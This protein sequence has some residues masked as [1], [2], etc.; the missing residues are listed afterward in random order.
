[1]PS[2]TARNAIKE[3][4]FTLYGA[5]GSWRKVAEQFDISPAMAWRIVKQDYEPKDTEIRRKLGLPT[6]V[7]TFQ[8][9]DGKFVKVD[10]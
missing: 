3:R 9:P 10:K 5:Y 6:P 7:T 4:L 1:M 2:F 8:G